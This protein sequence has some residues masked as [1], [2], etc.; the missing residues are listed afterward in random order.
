MT[1][2]FARS[3]ARLAVVTGPGRLEPPMEGEKITRNNA[4]RAIRGAYAPQWF[5]VAAAV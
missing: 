2:S 5:Y 1:D 4:L 3:A